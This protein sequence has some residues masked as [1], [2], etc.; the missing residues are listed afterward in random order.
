MIYFAQI[1]IP[2]GPVK[3]GTAKNVEK[4]MCELQKSM[5]WKLNVIALYPGDNKVEKM[6]HDRLF[7][8][9]MK[10][11]VGREWFECNEELLFWMNNIIITPTKIFFDPDA[12]FYPRNRLGDTIRQCWKIERY[13]TKA[14][15]SFTILKR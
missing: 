7:R 5:P 6:I 15:K 11:S 2:N 3:I 8:F 9:K 10:R 12:K 14:I 1:D 13:P 4:R